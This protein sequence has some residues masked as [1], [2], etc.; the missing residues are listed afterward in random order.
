[1]KLQSPPR[2]SETNVSF[3]LPLR[4]YSKAA[5]FLAVVRARDDR[6]RTP[7]EEPRKWSESKVTIEV[8]V[9]SEFH[10]DPAYDG[11]LHRADMAWAKHAAGCGMTLEQIKAELLAGRDLGKKGNRRRQIEYAERTARKAVE[12]LEPKRARR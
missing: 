5:E 11:D 9:V 1:M 2:I 10:R 7:A 12:Q 4:V 8:K 6:L 3:N